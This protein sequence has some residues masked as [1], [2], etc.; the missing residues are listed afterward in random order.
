MNLKL[1]SKEDVLQRIKEIGY[2]GQVF[3]ISLGE[4]ICFDNQW[5][6]VGRIS[7]QPHNQSSSETEIRYDE[8]YAAKF[9]GF[10][11]QLPTLTELNQNISASLIE[12]KNHEEAIQKAF[13]EG[14]QD[15]IRRMRLLLPVFDVEAM[16]NMPLRKPMTIVPDTSAV[17][18]GALDFVCHFLIPWARIKV[19]AIV[20]MEN[21]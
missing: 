1:L 16:A 5:I 14:L 9:G 13:R 12:S 15:V 10:E 2:E 4:D 11:W 6:N 3:E 7:L 8:C 19:P 17:Q 21:R 18:Q 20:H